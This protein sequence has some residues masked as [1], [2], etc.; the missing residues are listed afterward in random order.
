MIKQLRVDHSEDNSGNSRRPR[1]GSR[2][3]WGEPTSACERLE[4]WAEVL[5]YTLRRTVNKACRGSILGVERLN[6]E[7]IFHCGPDD[8][9]GPIPDEPRTYH[10]PPGTTGISHAVCEES[11]TSGVVYVREL[12]FYTKHDE[13]RCHPMVTLQAETGRSGIIVQLHLTCQS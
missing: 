13:P 1:E 2:R 9:K 12:D 7:Y 3:T 8:F 10:L 5:G 4:D 11:H 6:G